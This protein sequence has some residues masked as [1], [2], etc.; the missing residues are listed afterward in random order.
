MTTNPTTFI[1]GR[2]LTQKTSGVQRFAREIVGALDRRLAAQGGRDQGEWVL[3]MPP[4]AVCDLDLAVIRPLHTGT[5]QG[6]LWEQADLWRMTRR[7]RLVNLCN[8]G[9]VLHGRSLTVIHDAMIFRTPENFSLAYRLVHT[10]LGRILARRGRIGTVSEFSRRELRDTLG[11]LDVAV[12]PN[13]CEHMAAIRPDDAVLERLGLETGGYVMF[14]GS[15]TPN[16]NIGRA[17]E[18]IGLMGE[19]APKFVVV[20]AAAGAVFRTGNDGVNS[21]RQGRVLFAGRLSD[22]AV[23][24]LYAHA[25]GL[26]F[27]SLYEGFGI[28]PLEAMLAG[29]PVLASDIEPAREVCG[30]AA[31]YFDARNPRAIAAAIRT[32]LE[33]P[34]LARELAE[35]GLIRSA[36]FSW[37]RSAGALLDAVAIL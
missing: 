21:D 6:H 19:A 13:S 12:I 4:G 25:A 2:F 29:C 34:G 22:E 30:D 11:A 27:P 17:V 10:T 18:A 7:G 24:A 31:L 20:G 26:V 36:G 3:V 33:D 9:P 1:N 28:P 5:Y 14:V 32:L 8:S 35:R 37:Q 15:P 16:K 23:V